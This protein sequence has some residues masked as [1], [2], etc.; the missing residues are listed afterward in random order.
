MKKTLLAAAVVSALVA[1]TAAS[2]ATVYDKDGTTLK[3]NARI[4]AQWWNA[5]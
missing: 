2:A 4:E 1:S 3:V 5:G